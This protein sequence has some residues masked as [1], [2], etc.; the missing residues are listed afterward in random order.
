MLHLLGREAR[1][2]I[3]YVSEWGLIVLSALMGLFMVGMRRRMR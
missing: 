1:S 3:G 2:L